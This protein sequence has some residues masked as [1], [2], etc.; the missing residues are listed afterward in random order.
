MSLSESLRSELQ[1]AVSCK[2]RL[3]SHLI[4]QGDVG[5]SNGVY[6]SQGGHLIEACGRKQKLAQGAAVFPLN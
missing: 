2:M 4:L 1:D 3:R 6:V 5:S